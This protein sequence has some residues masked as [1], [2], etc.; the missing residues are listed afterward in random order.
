MKAAV[1]LIFAVYDNLKFQQLKK[2]K[3]MK[4]K[5]VLITI[6]VITVLVTMLWQTD[7]ARSQVV[8]DGL[9]SYWTFDKGDIDGETVRDIVGGRDATIVGGDLN[10]VEG[11]F[12]NAL[13]FDGNDYLEYD[14]SGLPE[15][16]AERTMSAWV[17]PEGDGV[18]SVIEWGARVATNRCSILVLAGNRIKFCGQNADLATGEAI[19]AEE[20]SLITET[21]DGATIRIYFDDRLVSS[22][23]I[24][25]DTK[26][27]GAAKKS[28]GR[29]GANVEV[30]PGEFM[31]G[32][33]DSPSIYDRML[34]DDEVVQNFEAGPLDLAV[35]AA[36][37]LAL[38][39]GAI[40]VS[41]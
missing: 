37:K 18:R 3:I 6:F 13:H 23:A 28:Y 16:K 9:L 4:A 17:Y 5:E 41:R 30:T 33:I 38:T 25:I 21:Y 7:T 36:G 34:D 26:L 1:D 24:A 40:K 8:T 12:G 22:Q 2:E 27:E 14:I 39:W 32:R 29:I 15:G 35:D 10:V 20:W 11:K 19:P 31:R